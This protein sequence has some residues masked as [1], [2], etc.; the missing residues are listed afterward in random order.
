MQMPFVSGIKEVFAK[1]A[2]S[3][4]SNMSTIRSSN[5]LSELSDGSLMGAGMVKERSG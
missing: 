3:V 2:Q 4:S 5:R 1:L